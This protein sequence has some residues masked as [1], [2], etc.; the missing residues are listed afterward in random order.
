MSPASPSA[1]L[2]KLRQEVSIFNSS[3]RLLNFSSKG[4]FQSPLI[5][6]AGDLFLEKWLQSKGPLP[7]E[8]F[9]PTGATYTAQQKLYQLDSFSMVLREKAEDF[10]ETDLYLVLGFLKWDGNALA[11]ALLVPVD[12]D[13]SKNTLTLSSRPPIENVVLRER[14]KDVLPSPLPKA[15][16]AVINGLFS[17]KLY[18][19]L[20][21]KAIATVRNWKFTRHGI[22]L[23]FFNTTRLLSR[24][25]FERGFNEKKVDASSTLSA[26]LTEN[27][28]EVQ[29]SLFE[30]SDV[31]HLFSPADYHFPY[32]TDSHTSK[33]TLDA[34][35]DATKA[36]AIQ[37]L[38][39][40]AKYK[41]VT[42]IV[43]ETVSKGKSVLVVSRRTVS[44]SSFKNTWNPPFRNYQSPERSVLEAKLRT[45]R[46]D[47]VDYYDAVN[48]PLQPSGVLLGDLLNELANTKPSKVK[49][50]DS[51][52]QG[53]LQLDYQSYQDLKADLQELIRL[54]FEQKGFEAHKAF[55]TVHV[56]SLSTDQKVKLANEL[57]EAANSVTE[58]DAI[59]SIM[60][61]AGLFPAG[62]LLAN[63]AE[64]LKLIQESFDQDTPSFEQ[65]ELR[66]NNWDSYKDT[67]LNLPKAG[68]KWAEYRR[69]TSEVYTDNAVDENILAARDD[70]A[71]SQKIALKGLSDRY[72][73][74]RKKLLKVLRNPRAVGSD[75]A[76]LELID[77]LLE[78]QEHKR[79]YKES[80]VLGNR[81][82]GK[83]WLYERSNWNELESKIQYV[84]DFRKKYKGTVKFE[85]L[86]QILEQWHLF[87]EHLPKLSDYFAAVQKLQSNISQISKDMCLETP[88]ESLSIEKWLDAI[89]SWSEN[90]ENLDIHV[91]L[92]ALFKKFEK[93]NCPGLL[94]FIQDTD[95]VNK[96]V[97]QQVTQYWTAH[98]IQNA[99]RSCP[100]LF[101]VSPKARAKKAKEYRDLLDSFGNANFRE[102]HETVEQHPELLTVA[103]LNETFNLAERHFDLA[104]I[105]DADSI[106][107]VGALP[108]IMQAE[109]VILVGDPHNPPLEKQPFDAYQEQ[110]LSHTPLFVES[111]LTTALR[112]GIPTR[113]LWFASSFY[114]DPAL[115]DFANRHI[116]NRGI[117]LFSAPTRETFKG[118]HLKTVQDKVLSIAQ[119]AIRHAEKNPGKTLGIIA[120]HQ[121]T[122]H[123]IESAIRAMLMADSPA[124]RFFNQ[125]N[126]NIRYFIKTPERAVDRYRDVLLVCAEAEGG[127]SIVADRKISVCTTLAK[128]E[129]WVYI[130]ESDLSKQG[131]A[132]QNL[133]WTWISYLQAKNFS[134]ETN[135]SL[136]PSVIR[137]QVIESL[138]AEQIQAE[139][140]LNRGGISL[141]PVVVDANNPNH[142]LALIEDDCTTER[143]RTSVEDREYIRPTLLKQLGW[144][145]LNLWLP[146]WHMARQDEIGHL[147]ATIAIEQSVAP[148][149]PAPQDEDSDD[150]VFEKSSSAMVVPYQV[151]HPK[152]EGTPHDKPIAELPVAALITQVKFYIDRESPIHQDILK[153]RVLELH[154]VDRAGPIIQQALTEA[155]NQGLQKK[156]FVKTGPFFY[157]LKP[158]EVVPRNRSG[159]PDSERKLAYVAPEERSKM[160]ASMDEH[161]LKQAL[162]L[163]E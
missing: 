101:T 20:F 6:E 106:S 94:K 100:S 86:L 5:M 154:H 16:D 121:A 11:P 105:L 21:E 162:G 64:I 18:Y 143:F 28:F 17:I 30:N 50:P 4:D 41:V 153:S 34:L 122:C 33:V 9:F 117:K 43:A 53:I 15:E 44:A 78:H 89:K 82:L 51:F 74:S 70:F 7:L 47:A 139:E 63:L 37:S 96:D 144:K 13:N 128:N 145:V 90:W 125:Q 148:P 146:F 108:G 66:S 147:V 83:D 79:A 42:N 126:L 26:L 75:D 140:S 58:L 71:E 52:F 92:T 158:G 112:K 73:S 161:N 12:F 159:R 115:V 72:R 136:A 160:P 88:L 3:D 163:L 84:Y 150:E 40:T 59:I 135:S 49:Y 132:K 130:S 80:S 93:Y 110:P 137:P 133:F 10:G 124:A 65:W 77:K 8:S 156:R 111:V 99:T 81:L 138:G 19:S 113:E 2:S 120:F 87:K 76:L 67:L 39:G 129:T 60:E 36:Y 104:I 62:T 61:N 91:Q 55:Q 22:C 102:F 141:G 57:S 118:I 149:P 85:Q 25:W 155:I 157:S 123:E 31:D 109:K 32:V 114:G 38:P 103:H 14:L 46:K 95:N 48:K 142:F 29:E 116:Y 56:P 35:N 68:A 98:T 27:G 1:T 119:A 107:V 45:M 24:N 152:I 127:T 131:S 134:C 151:Q 97:L 23:G 69:T 54:Y